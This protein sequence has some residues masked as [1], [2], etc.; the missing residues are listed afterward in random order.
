MQTAQLAVTL[1][2]ESRKALIGQEELLP[3][4]LLSDRHGMLKSLP[5]AAKT[6][7]VKA[8]AQLIRPIFAVFGSYSL[9]CR[10]TS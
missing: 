4:P 6:L 3:L 1:S 7:T 5:G 9:L 10:L 8:L 2:T